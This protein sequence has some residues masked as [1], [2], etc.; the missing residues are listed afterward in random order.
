MI[1]E[2]D[3]EKLAKAKRRFTLLSAEDQDILIKNGFPFEKT[4]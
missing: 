2:V 1:V 4:K 3:G